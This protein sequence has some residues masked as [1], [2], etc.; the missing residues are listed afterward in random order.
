MSGGS[1]VVVVVAEPDMCPPE[2]AG[3]TSAGNTGPKCR[4]QL[5]CPERQQTPVIIFVIIL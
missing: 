4:Q 3:S 1:G 2:P 5:G